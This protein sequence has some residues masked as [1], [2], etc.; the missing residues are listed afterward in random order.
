VA[1]NLHKSFRDQ[2]VRSL[3]QRY[4]DREIELEHV[5][6][7]LKI[8]RSRF[9]ALLRHFR[10]N[11]SEFSIV[12]QKQ[13][14]T[15]KIS[16]EIERNILRE[17][18]IEKAMIEN[19]K[20][21]LDTYNYTYIRDLLWDKYRQRVCV[22]TIIKRAKENDFYPRRPKRKA[23]DR[24]VLTNYIG[25]LIQHDSSHHLWAPLAETKWYLI[26][27]IDDYSRYLLYA[28]LVE[29]ETSWDHISALESVV[30]RWGIPYAYYTDSHSIFRFVQGRDSNWR[31][32]YLVT[33]DVDPQWKQ[34]LR[35]L[36]I[37][38][39]HALSPQA[40]GKVERPYG[41]LQDRLVRTCA[42]ENIKMI[43]D[44]REVLRAELDRY[45]NHQVHNTTGEIP[46]YRFHRARKEKRMLFREFLVPPPFLSTKDIFCLRAERVVNPYRR[47][48]FNN[49]EFKLSGVSPR[50]TIQ[51][52][53]VPFP[54][55]G[56]AEFR[57]WHENRFLGS[58]KARL[59]DINLVHF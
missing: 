37:Q 2:R 8:G 22:P 47:I 39:R 48:S 24:Q 35:E 27:S 34:V 4:L 57:F 33:D 41:W 10:D 16:P 18:R 51:I 17:L 20:I 5:L 23:H 21:K 6:G 45:N 42:R 54:D 7:I 30:L 49:L 29:R 38:F 31:K 15:R 58:Q 56:L 9:F 53:L 12:Y 11:P 44:A 50:E 43:H 52:R 13:E 59:E 14:A 28:D 1:K 40:K 36:Q 26:T 25:E 46:A 19:P 3:L 32:H 55:R